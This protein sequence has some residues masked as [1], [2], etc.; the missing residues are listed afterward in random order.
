[1]P[2]FMVVEQLNFHL[3]N[4]P[5]HQHRELLLYQDG[6]R[7]TIWEAIGFLDGKD[8]DW[9]P[10][11]F[12]HRKEIA[13]GWESQMRTRLKEEKARLLAEGFVLCRPTLPE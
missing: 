7:F 12:K 13:M 5:S 6:N 11:G 10:A 8:A 3:K 2:S 1:M 4:D 9:N